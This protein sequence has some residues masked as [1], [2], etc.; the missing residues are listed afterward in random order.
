M[1]AYALLSCLCISNRTNRLKKRSCICWR[2]CRVGAWLIITASV[3]STA[4]YEYPDHYHYRWCLPTEGMQAHTPY[5]RARPAPST[6]NI[7]FCRRLYTDTR[8]S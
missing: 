4:T 2:A 5:G 1:V 3:S 8:T 7:H 6:Y